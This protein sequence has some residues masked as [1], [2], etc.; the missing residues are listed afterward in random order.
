MFYDQGLCSTE[1]VCFG[2]LDHMLDRVSSLSAGLSQP[3]RDAEWGIKW[4]ELS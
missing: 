3:V 1:S 2:Y 4:G